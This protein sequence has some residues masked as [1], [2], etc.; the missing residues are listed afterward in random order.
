MAIL[1]NRSEVRIPFG[2]DVFVAFAAVVTRPPRTTTTN[3]SANPNPQSLSEPETPLPTPGLSHPTAYR[4]SQPEHR[5]PVKLWLLSETHRRVT[6][7]TPTT[8]LADTWGYVL[9]TG[10]LTIYGVHTRP[11][12]PSD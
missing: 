1:V 3:A 11:L 9:G 12:I 8:Q 7:D 2:P 10:I 4:A 6:L 5:I